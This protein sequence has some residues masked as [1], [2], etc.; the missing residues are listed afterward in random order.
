MS[1]KIIIPSEYRHTNTLIRY[2]EN[3]NNLGGITMPR[4]L[5]VHLPPDGK[6]M[7]PGVRC[8]LKC[9]FCQGRGFKPDFAN[10]NKALIHLIQRLDGAIP[11]IVFSGLY[12]DPTLNS[13]LIEI[14][15]E[16]K[17]S[18]ANFG[19]HTNGVLLNQLEKDVGFLSRMF[20]VGTEDDYLSISFYAVTLE[21]FKKT[22]RGTF[23]QYVDLLNVF[24]ESSTTRGIESFSGSGGYSPKVRLTY[25]ID[26]YNCSLEH[27]EWLISFA[28]RFLLDSLRF[29]VTYAPFSASIE[30][31]LDYRVRFELPKFERVRKFLEQIVSS[32]ENDRPFIFMRPPGEENIISRIFHCFSMMDNL[33]IGPDGWIYPCCSVAHNTYEH[34]R[35]ARLTDDFEMFLSAI[36]DSQENELDPHKKCFPFGARCSS[37]SANINSYFILEVLGGQI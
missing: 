26:K 32:D 15:E 16:V 17:K 1:S 9:R 37:A 13:G 34:L 3:P 36:N 8:S 22:T 12:T 4:Q 33:V 30:D 35:I 25:L 5:E 19:I 23:G 10:F 6:I 7:D 2:M 18:G 28:E 11:N 31:S 20:G 24:G 29:S 27:L 14:I 21:A